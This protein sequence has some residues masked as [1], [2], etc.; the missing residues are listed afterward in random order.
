MSKITEYASAT[1]F[2]S[3]DVLL[4]DGTN[5]TKKITFGNAAV[6]FAGAVSAMNHRNVY[7]GKN[8]G[9][10]ITT[11]QWTAI[12]NGTFD[13]LF[14]GDYWILDGTMFDIADMDYWYNNGDSTFTKHHL[15]VIPHT[16][17]YYH[18]MNDTNTTEGGYVGS[19]MY[20]EGLAT[21]LTKFQ[22]AF[23][24]HLLTHREYLCNA[25]SN[26]VESG[27]AWLDSTIDLPSEIMVYGS[28]I[29]STSNLYTNGTQQLALFQLSPRFL[30]EVRNNSWLRDVV[31]STFFAY[32]NSDGAA[33]SNNASNTWYGVRPVGAIG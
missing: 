26:G 15:V 13:D 8:L 19:K 4:K 5:G 11:A 33:G 10:S 1:R 29:R 18:I 2:D 25:V 17:L 22:T 3:G 21:A 20:T 23:G 27:G 24:S 12:S 7:R 14:I 31:S 9:T 30:K 32:V 28:R 6:E 16:N